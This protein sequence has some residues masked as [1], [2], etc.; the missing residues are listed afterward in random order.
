MIGAEAV[1]NMLFGTAEVTHVFPELVAQ[2]RSTELD[3]PNT[4]F[5]RS[6]STWIRMLRLW[7]DVRRK[8]SS[9]KT[10]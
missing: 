10:H 9:V 3:Y 2:Q 1:D 6:G 8:E 7:L 5:D 4:S